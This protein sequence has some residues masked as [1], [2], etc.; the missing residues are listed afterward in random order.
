MVLL[1]NVQPKIVLVSA[2]RDHDCT[3]KLWNVQAHEIYNHEDLKV[4]ATELDAFLSGSPM[5][6]DFMQFITDQNPESSQMK[7]FSTRVSEYFD[8]KCLH[9]PRDLVPQSTFQ[10]PR[11]PILALTDALDSQDYVRVGKGVTHWARGGESYDSRNLQSQ[12]CCLQCVLN[13][14]WLHSKGPKAI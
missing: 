11:V 5:K 3:R 10:S 8:A 4:D 1:L 14:V 13:S 9:S 2:L 12:R 7:L 6:F